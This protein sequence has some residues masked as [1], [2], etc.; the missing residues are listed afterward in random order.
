V[1]V[2][3]VAFKSGVEDVRADNVPAILVMPDPEAG[4]GHHRLYFDWRPVGPELRSVKLE[5]AKQVAVVM[6][7]AMKQ[8]VL[9]LALHLLEHHFDADSG[10]FRGESVP[11]PDVH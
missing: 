4:S 10:E 1:T 11:N 9:K 5:M 3:T 6:D 7:Y 2:A 8:G